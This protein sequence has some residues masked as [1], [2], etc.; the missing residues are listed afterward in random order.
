MCPCKTA[1]TLA[2]DCHTIRT[3]SLQIDKTP[4]ATRGE[5]PSPPLPQNHTY[6]ETQRPTHQRGCR[7]VYG[8]D[9]EQE[10]PA[11]TASKGLKK[12]R[13]APPKKPPPYAGVVLPVDPEQAKTQGLPHKGQHDFG[14]WP[15]PRT[16]GPSMPTRASTQQKHAHDESPCPPHQ[17][18][19]RPVYGGG[20]EQELAGP[21]FHEF[22]APTAPNGWKKSTTALPERPPPYGEVV[23]PVDP[24]QARAWGCDTKG[25]MTLD[26]GLRRV[27]LPRKGRAAML[28]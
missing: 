21:V 26:A 2:L 18:S 27:R 4:K 8:G 6:G 20:P 13:T 28:T 24:E 17:R 22:R 12:P 1:E 14:L 16:T 15:P 23:L 10:Q 11:S 9:P 3:K 5:A 7:R 25:S 19:Y